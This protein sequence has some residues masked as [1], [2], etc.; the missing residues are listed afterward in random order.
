MSMLSQFQCVFIDFTVF[1][2]LKK[3]YMLVCLDEIVCKWIA[4]KAQNC[5]YCTLQK[6][7]TSSN[8]IKQLFFFNK[9]LQYNV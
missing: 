4:E 7:A 3:V 2:M 8:T 6:F 1:C 5:L 9:I